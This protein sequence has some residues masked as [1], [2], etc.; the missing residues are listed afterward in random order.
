LKATETS[1]VAIS[2]SFSPP[3]GNV[4]SVTLSNVTGHLSLTDYADVRGRA[5]Y[6]VGDFLPYGFFGVVVGAGNYGISTQVD[7]F[8]GASECVGF[9]LSP[10]AGQGNAVLWDFSVGFGLD[11]ALM[12]NVFVRG[13]FDFDQFAPVSHI[14]LEIVSA[15]VGAGIKF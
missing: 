4:T 5:G 10:S 13:E 11:W 9:P 14:S 12:P 3:A 7:A 8:C 6:V 15:R 2:R 1:S